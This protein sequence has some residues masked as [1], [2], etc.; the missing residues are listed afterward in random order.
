MPVPPVVNSAPIGF[1]LV[2]LG[3]APPLVTAPRRTVP[4]V[5]EAICA[6]VKVGAKEHTTS[7]LLA[8]APAGA[9]QDLAVITVPSAW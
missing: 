1:R 4:S 8:V 5:A 9:A 3:V 6:W 7:M 2:A